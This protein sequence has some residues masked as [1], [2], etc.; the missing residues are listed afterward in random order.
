MD[1]PLFEISSTVQPNGFV[2]LKTGKV[3]A[4]NG[5]ILNTVYLR[6]L[7]VEMIATL[8][9]LFSVIP[10]SC[11]VRDIGVENGTIQYRGFR[12]DKAILFYE[13]YVSFYEEKELNTVVDRLVRTIDQ[14]IALVDNF[15]CAF[16]G[17]NN[18]TS[19]DTETCRLF[20]SGACSV[21]HAEDTWGVK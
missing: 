15:R 3:Y 1:T 19:F 4:Y 9:E 5:S 11:Q 20:C 2:V 12:D 13:T 14:C 17:A 6:T 21:N 18:A 7:S 8:E 10:Y 16:C